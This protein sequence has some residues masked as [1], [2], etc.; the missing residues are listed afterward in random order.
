MRISDWSSDVCSSDLFSLAA[1][2]GFAY[3]VKENGQTRSMAKLAPL[4]VLGAILCAEPMVFGSRE[5]SVTW[6][7]YVGIG[8]IV[9]GAIL[10]FR[11]PIASK[12]PSLE[13][14]ADIMYRALR[15]EEHTSELQSLIRISYA[16]SCLK[17]KNIK[18]TLM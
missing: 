12:L 17:K 14:L 15:S 3:L 9:V 1:M 5:L 10:A 6:M 11:G 7:L 18:H 2:V 8:A 16:V 4:F 13:I